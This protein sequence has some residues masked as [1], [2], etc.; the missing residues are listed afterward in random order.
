MAID[1]AARRKLDENVHDLYFMIGKCEEKIAK[2]LS[3][4]AFSQSNV[5]TEAPNEVGNESSPHVRQYERM[6]QSA[7]E[8]YVLNLNTPTNKAFV[9]YLL[10]RSSPNNAPLFCFHFQLQL[11]AA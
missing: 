2:T 5:E 11:Q 7:L 4:E 3:G 10:I 6:L 1:F 9:F 8:R